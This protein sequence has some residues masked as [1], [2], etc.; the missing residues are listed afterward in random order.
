MTELKQLRD[1][2]EEVNGIR[3]RERSLKGVV[4]NLI[5]NYKGGGGGTDSSLYTI[6]DVLDILDGKKLNTTK[7][8]AFLTNLGVDL[9]TSTDDNMFA[10]RVSSIY[11]LYGTYI[12]I[13]GISLNEFSGSDVSY[14]YTFGNSIAITEHGT[15]KTL[16]E[17]I[18]TVDTD[19]ECVEDNNY[20]SIRNEFYEENQSIENYTYVPNIIYIGIGSGMQS[21]INFDWQDLF[22]CFDVINNA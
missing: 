6:F 5:S 2:A 18:N 10:I 13:F 19:E 11:D 9:T 4:N 14:K 3:P 20:S 15:V 1:F 17:L 12:G 21:I 22:A 7:F 8:K 16:E